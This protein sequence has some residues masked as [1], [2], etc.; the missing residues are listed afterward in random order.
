MSFGILY[1]FLF[2]GWEKAEAE[3]L[4]LKQQLES[5][6]L[7]RLTAEDRASHLDGALKECMKQVR[8]VKEESEQ[9]LH[10]V[11]FAKT[12]QWEKA[13]LSWEQKLLILNKS[14]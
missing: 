4:A 8:N 2:I 6:T 14:F 3:A 12:K 13:R 11:V 7:L 9:K 1:F 5:V 10:D